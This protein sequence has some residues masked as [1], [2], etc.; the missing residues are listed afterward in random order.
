MVPVMKTMRHPVA[1]PFI[2]AVLLAAIL[3]AAGCTLPSS[4][5]AP[6]ATPTPEPETTIIP[7]ATTAAIACGLSTCHGLD[8][9][10]VPNPPGICTTEYKLGDRCRKYVHCENSGG[11]CTLV[12]DTGFS[13]CKT[14]VEACEL[15][16]GDDT[17]WAQ[18]CE[19]KC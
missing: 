15:R 4:K 8:L 3:M 9:A 10:C 12:K 11:S 1:I 5:P 13:T 16:G 18:S 19:E 7:T 2:C 17:L 6:V 14:C